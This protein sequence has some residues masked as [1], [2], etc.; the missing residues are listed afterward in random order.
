MGDAPIRMGDAPIRMGDAPIRMGVRAIRMGD[1]AIRIGDT[2]I[3]MG[4]APIRMG[5]TAIAMGGAP[6]RMGDTAIGM[7]ERA[8]RMGEHPIQMGERAIRSA[9]LRSLIASAF[10]VLAATLT[11]SAGARVFRA[12]VPARLR[13]ACC[14]S[15]QRRKQRSR[16][17]P[18]TSPQARTSVRVCPGLRTSRSPSGSTYVPQNCA[19]SVDPS[20]ANVDAAPPRSPRTRGRSSPCRPH[21]G[22]ASPC[23]RPSRSRIRPAGARSTRPFRSS[24]TCARGRTCRG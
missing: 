15:T 14:S 9:V 3:A 23:S 1:P 21:A 7:G 6:I 18:F 4:G 19:L 22:G 2:A 5:D 10:K 12:H 8:I 13:G 17:A 24:C 20:S 16:G 11:R